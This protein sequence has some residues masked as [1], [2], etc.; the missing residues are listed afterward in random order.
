MNDFEKE[1][2]AENFGKYINGK[3]SFNTNMRATGK[4]RRILAGGENI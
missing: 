4:Y 3:L 1:E 2:A